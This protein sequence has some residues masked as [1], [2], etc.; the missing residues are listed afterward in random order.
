MH[1]QEHPGP[2]WE[3]RQGFLEIQSNKLQSW[4]DSNCAEVLLSGYLIPLA[5]KD[6][7]FYGQISLINLNL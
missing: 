1:I 3:D 7:Q 4:Q 6:G 5:K 2:V